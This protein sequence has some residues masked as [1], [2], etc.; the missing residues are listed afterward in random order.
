MICWLAFIVLIIAGFWKTFEKAG[1]PGW[2]A[3]I[4]IYNLYVLCQIAGRPGWWVLLYFI[5]FVNIIVSLL[6]AID[7]AKAFGKDVVYGVVLL[8]FFQAIGYLLLG[9]GDAQYIGPS[10]A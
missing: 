1:Q 2:A 8:W 5:P 9:F 7:V 3:I 4:P 10:K 6:I